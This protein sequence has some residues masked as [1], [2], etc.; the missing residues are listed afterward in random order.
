MK[1]IEQYKE[2]FY[3]LMESTMGDVRPLISEQSETSPQL[4]PSEPP[5]NYSE[6]NKSKP[7]GATIEE[8]KYLKRL[9]QELEYAKDQL[10]DEKELVG[11]TLLS[12]IKDYFKVRKLRR[13]NEKLESQ[14]RLLE[15][16][17]QRYKDG[18]II[19]NENGGLIATISLILIYITGIIAGP[20]LEKL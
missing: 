12:R 5:L 4:P 3:N 1:N 15:K 16:D 10:E 2:R 7:F 8:I 20:D 14:L 17:I 19:G 11:G 6:P 9:Q 13:Q 18:K